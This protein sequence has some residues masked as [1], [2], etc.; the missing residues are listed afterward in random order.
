VNRAVRVVTSGRVL[1]GSFL[2]ESILGAGWEDAGDPSRAEDARRMR[3]GRILD[4]TTEFESG[5]ER[6]A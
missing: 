4:A 6:V 1:V 2:V 5:Q 3:R